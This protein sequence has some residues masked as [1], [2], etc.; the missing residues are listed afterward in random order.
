MC[1]FQ[2]KS[3]SAA[4][5]SMTACVNNFRKACDDF[6]MRQSSK[7]ADPKRRCTGTS[8]RNGKSL[9]NS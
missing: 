7:Q 5:S 8:S 2:K 6:L 9:S 3:E 1:I 4:S